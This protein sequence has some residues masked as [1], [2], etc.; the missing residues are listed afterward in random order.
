MT[1]T[2]DKQINVRTRVMCRLN[3]ELYLKYGEPEVIN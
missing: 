2:K 1:F 3:I